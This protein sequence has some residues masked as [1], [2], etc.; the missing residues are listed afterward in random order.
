[1]AGP[2]SRLLRATPAQTGEAKERLARSYLEH[3]GLTHLAHNVRCRH[4]EIDLVMRDADTLVFVEVRYRRSE[5]FGGAR[6]SIDQRKRARLAAAAAFYLQRPPSPLP[7]RFD[8]IAIGAGD[9]VDWIRNAFD[10]S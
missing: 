4:G 2:L 6:A 3:H 5:R 7:C 9:R 8:V 10:Q 1:M